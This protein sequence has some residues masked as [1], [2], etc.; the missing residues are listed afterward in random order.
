MVELSHSYVFF[1]LLFF[2]SFHL[3]NS[4]KSRSTCGLITLKCFICLGGVRLL[5]REGAQTMAKPRN[6]FKIMFFTSSCYA[7]LLLRQ[8]YPNVINR[9][10][11][12]HSTQCAVSSKSLQQ[13]NKHLS[14][15]M[16]RL[17]T[18]AAF[19]GGCVYAVA[20]AI[21]EKDRK[22]FDQVFFFAL[23]RNEQA[24]STLNVCQKN[25]SELK[26]CC[27][28]FLMNYARWLHYWYYQMRMLS[29][30]E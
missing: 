22:I 8:K 28:S 12:Q 15:D 5:Q 2:R 16:S 30:E 13:W 25:Y 3:E 27:A 11:T 4:T 14:F 23:C 1:L 6:C 29:E 10:R 24:I 21:A 7:E 9:Y 20:R 18:H 26:L 19:C 17:T